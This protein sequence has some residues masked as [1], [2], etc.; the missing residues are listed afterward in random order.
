MAHQVSGS[1]KTLLEAIRD[2][3]VP[4]PALMGWNGWQ[5]WR[6]TSG[7]MPRQA[8]DG[9]SVSRAQESALWKS[10]MLDLYGEDWSL[11]LVSG[12]ADAPDPDTAA[13]PTEAAPPTTT[14]G[15]GDSPGSGTGAD[16]QPREE[17]GRT[18]SNPGSGIATPQ[19]WNSQAPGTPGSLTKRVMTSFR[20]EVETLEQYTDRVERQ[21]R[22][23]ELAEAPL[24]EG[25]LEH[26]LSR[27]FYEQLLHTEAKGDFSLQA[28]V[29][30]R[31][32]AV[33]YITGSTEGPG[34]EA[35]IAALEALL[36]WMSLS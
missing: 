20:P 8:T 15:P 2:G 4:R 32:Y 22:A 23:L 1:E 25:V 28:R 10:V 7:R 29:L 34:Q 35:H 36:Q 12:E 17:A 11:Q 3:E 24:A 14:S 6:S 27:A 16:G 13:S 18:T 5:S 19:S 31:E 26:L 9:Y 21:A 30:P 33:E